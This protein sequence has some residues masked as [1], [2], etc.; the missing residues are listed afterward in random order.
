MFSKSIINATFGF[1]V[2]I[3]NESKLIFSQTYD[4]SVYAHLSKNSYE[5]ATEAYNQLEEREAL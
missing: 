4:E 1:R 3:F 2:S 5:N